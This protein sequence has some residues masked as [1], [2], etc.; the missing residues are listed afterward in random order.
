MITE[1]ILGLLKGSP[2]LGV[3]LFGLGYLVKQASE[4]F[5]RISAERREWRQL[6]R[7][8][9]RRLRPPAAQHV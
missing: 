5:V 6:Q 7:Q 2:L 3:G 1:M 8:M 9:T 4:A